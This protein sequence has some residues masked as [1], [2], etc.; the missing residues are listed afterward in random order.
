MKHQEQIDELRARLTEAEETLRAIHEGEVDAVVVSG[1]KGIQVY[2]LT[3]AE[4][5]YR[6]IV[7]TM[8]EAA[9]TVAL[10]GR[11]LYCNARFGELIDRPLG[12]VI[13]H[14]LREFAAPGSIAMVESML[15]QTRRQPVRQRLV[16]AGAYGNVV[17]VHASAH[18]L[19]QSADPAICIVAADLTDIETSSAELARMVE[20]LKQEV[21]R[22]Q[23]A[24]EVLR[25][26][27]ERLRMLASQLTL[28]EQRE[29]RRLAS[30]VHDE[31]QQLLVGA[32]Y[33]LNRVDRSSKSELQQ[34]ILEVS[35]LVN[36]AVESSRSLT[37]EL[38]PPVLQAGGLVAA[39]E[40]LVTWMRRQHGLIVRLQ[41]DHRVAPSEDVTVLL[42]HSIREL[43]FNTVQHAGVKEAQVRL[44]RKGRDIQVTVSDGGSGFDPEAVASR[45]GTTGGFGL[46]SIRE[47]LD[48]MGGRMEIDSAVGR[49]SRIILR[50]ARRRTSGMTESDPPVTRANW[51]HIDGGPRVKE[52][53]DSGA[54]IRVLLVD[55]HIAVRAGLTCLLRGESDIEVVG[56]ASDGATGIEM[57]RRLS[58]DLVMMD[59]KMPGME[60]I[61]A[62]RRIV[63][64]LP[65][66]G[67]IGLSMF[68]EPQHATAMRKAGALG[69]LAKSSPTEL[70]LSTIRACAGRRAPQ[71]GTFKKLSGRKPGG[72]DGSHSEPLS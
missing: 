2:S 56:E 33:R 32:G 26:R 48:L 11:I 40:W 5:S 61:E 22:R 71:S 28:A 20:K 55:D 50:L 30:M 70:L 53:V 38:S 9:L 62:T 17:P 52:T 42:F 6:L 47:R 8:K 66:V 19:H 49:G 35:E 29:R 46:F 54:R 45:V 3:S 15:D 18:L 27:G 72:K 51:A 24:E 69:Y 63:S 10:D 12:C 1:G 25:R 4:T 34:A 57:A 41:A 65:Y 37:A 58:P 16:L 64:E 68:E 23:L 44:Q 67:V 60:G 14:P 31:L 39:L 21:S 43:L 13:G 36:R 7:E 59:I